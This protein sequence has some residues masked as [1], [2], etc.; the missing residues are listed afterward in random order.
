MT[1]TKFTKGPWEFRTDKDGTPYVGTGIFKIVESIWGT[2]PS[3]DGTV[4]DDRI[5]NA[6][7][8]AAAPELYEALEE[9]LNMVSGDGHPPNWDRIREVLKAARGEQ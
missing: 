7:L 5:A 8:I 9:C 2:T 4:K 3:V 1:E 6:H